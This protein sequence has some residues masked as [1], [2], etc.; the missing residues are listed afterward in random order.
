MVRKIFLPTNLIEN[1]NK[2]KSKHVHSSTLVAVF[3][4]E[5]KQTNTLK[6][7]SLVIL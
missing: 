2:E 7:D 6:V 1:N 3:E 4:I 5:S